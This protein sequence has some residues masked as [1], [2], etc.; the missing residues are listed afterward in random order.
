[1]STIKQYYIKALMQHSNGAPTKQHVFKTF[2][3]DETQAAKNIED[4]IDNWKEVNAYWIMRISDQP[5]KLF[6]YLIQVEITHPT[7]KKLM[8]LRMMMEDKKEAKELFK[9][10]SEDWSYVDDFKIMSV[11]KLNNIKEKQ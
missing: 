5:I 6:P 2:A 3:A 9:A 8:K 11:T 10:F 4:L 1:M 7:R